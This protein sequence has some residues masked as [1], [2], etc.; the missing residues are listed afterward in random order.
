MLLVAAMPVAGQELE[1][2]TYSNTAVDVNLVGV[3][4]GYSRGNILLDPTLP[5]EDLIGDLKFGVFQYLRSFGLLGRSAKADLFVPFTGGDWRG[6]LEG[7]AAE[8][9]ATGFG[10]ARVTFSWNFSGAPAMRASEMADYR[11][12]T[13]VGGS[14]RI[15]IPTGDY[16]PSRLI[17][18]GSNRWSYRL[19][20]GASRA[21]GNWTIEGI[22]ALWTFGVNDDYFDGNRL[23][24]ERLWVAKT[25]LIYTFRPGY[26]VGAGLG[27]G[28]GGRT[29]VNGQPSDNRQENWRIGA[30]LAYPLNRKH[31]VS[32]TLG[33]GFNRGAGGDFD[34]VFLGYRYAWGAI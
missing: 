25:H 10:D 5:I 3:A 19:E 1:P 11:Q 6:S 31:G 7:V 14:V 32:V 2:R 16:D 17:N 33:S 20:L 12:G 4:A 34:S 9:K 13:I 26:W 29:V 21:I 28:A 18:L 23:Q 8:R 15:V 24:Q 22:G 30:T 27:Y